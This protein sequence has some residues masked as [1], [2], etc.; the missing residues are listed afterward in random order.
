MKIHFVS[1]MGLLAYKTA[2]KK[3]C[4]AGAVCILALA[5]RAQI[6]NGSFEN[7]FTGWHTTPG[8]FIIG[9]DPNEPIGTDGYYSADLGGDDITGAVL[10]QTVSNFAHGGTYQ[11]NYDSVCNAGY[12]LSNVAVWDVVIAAD[13]QEIARQTVSQQNVG[14]PTGSFGF[15]HRQMTFAMLSS[16]QD[17]TISFV[18]MTPGGGVGI[19]AAFDQVAVTSV[20]EPGGAAMTGLAVLIGVATRAMRRSAHAK[21]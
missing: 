21:R 18:D 17:I 3:I 14:W 12:D 10:S 4:L 6:F 15:L 20:P 16:A 2:Q 11:L 9:S 19:D 7:G 1:K 8:D 13:G 5:A